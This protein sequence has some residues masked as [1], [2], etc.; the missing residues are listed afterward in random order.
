PDRHI[1]AT[2]TSTSKHIIH[3]QLFDGVQ[4]TSAPQPASSGKTTPHC[5]DLGSPSRP[6]CHAIKLLPRFLIELVFCRAARPIA[7]SRTDERAKKSAEAL[8]CE[9]DRSPV[10]YQAQYPRAHL[11]WGGGFGVGESLAGEQGAL[12]LHATHLVDRAAHLHLRGDPVCDLSH[13][14]GNRHT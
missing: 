12:G 11:P 2:R 8:D 1:V 9:H 3:G 5:S 7:R 10:S 4:W 13:R 6:R 14:D